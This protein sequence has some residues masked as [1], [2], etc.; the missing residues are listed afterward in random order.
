MQQHDGVALSYFYVRHLAAENPPPMLLIRKCRRDHTAFS[1]IPC[2]DHVGFSFVLYAHAVARTP[3]L[4]KAE[5]VLSSNESTAKVF[6]YGEMCCLP[7]GQCL[8]E[9]DEKRMAV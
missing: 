7:G 5:R 9:Q 6:C 1:F 4:P 2:R 3:E 8:M